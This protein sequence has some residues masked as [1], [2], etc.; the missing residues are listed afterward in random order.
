LTEN[1]A[2]G[3][4][5]STPAVR[6]GSPWDQKPAMANNSSPVP[7]PA[8]KPFRIDVR[9]IRL[10][11]KALEYYRALKK[12]PPLQE[13]VQAED[14]IITDDL[15][16]VCTSECRFCNKVRGLYTVY[17]SKINIFL[18]VLL[19]PCP[20]KCQYVFLKDPFCIYCSQFSI[21][22]SVYLPLSF[23]FTHIDHF[24][25][26]PFKFFPQQLTSTV[27]PLRRGK[28]ILQNTHP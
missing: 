4:S 2:H 24:F 11:E 26:F 8:C 19:F 20:A 10:P 25:G 14:E 13:P 23:S 28:R 15:T 3:Q 7:P 16:N 9:K 21:L 22:I 17:Q 1:P 6:A 12:C 5:S 18:I 27:A